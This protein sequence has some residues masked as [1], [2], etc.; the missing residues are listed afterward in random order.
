MVEHTEVSSD[1]S[2]EEIYKSRWRKGFDGWDKTGV[3]YMILKDSICQKEV[4]YLRTG[5]KLRVKDKNAWS[6]E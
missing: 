5:W 6:Q 2:T 1:R 4:D 3:V